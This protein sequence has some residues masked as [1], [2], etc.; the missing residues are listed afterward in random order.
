MN[1]VEGNQMITESFTFFFFFFMKREYSSLVGVVNRPWARRSLN[2]IQFSAGN[3][4][5]VFSRWVQNGCGAQWEPFRWIK[6][7]IAFQ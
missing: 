6:A 1:L 7:V 4:I 5:S 3:A 2:R